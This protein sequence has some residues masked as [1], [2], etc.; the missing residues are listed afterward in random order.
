MALRRLVGTVHAIAV[1]ETGPRI[2]QVTVPDLV[3]AGGQRHARHLARG[4]GVEQ[5]QLD[6]RRHGRRKARN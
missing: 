2:G 3:G 4:V 5:T 1:D 6:P